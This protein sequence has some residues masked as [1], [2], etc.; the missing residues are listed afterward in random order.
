M[1][2][3]IQ[4]IAQADADFPEAIRRATP[5]PKQ[6]FIRTSHGQEF[7]TILDK[8]RVAIVGSRKVSPYG[9]TATQLLVSEL[10]RAGIVIVSGLAIGVDA[11]AHRTA[12]EVGGQTI[13]ILPGSVEEIYPRSH[14]QLAKQIV[15]Q[16]GALVSEYPPGTVT[17]PANFIA[18][19]RLVAALANV[20]LVIEA[21]QKSGTLHTTRFALEQGID[22]MAVPGNI[23]SPTSQGTNNLLRSGA[24]LATC[25][26]DVLYMLGLEPAQT[27]AAPRSSDP[28]EQSILDLLASGV[29]DGA[30]LLKGSNLEV[31]AYNQALTMLEISGHIRSLGAN[32]W[33][34]A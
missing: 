20:L 22:V 13:A 12:L 11:C 23:T 4:I 9:K 1:N 10:A 25:A 31:S 26:E 15:G 32:K 24:S 30:A 27:K 6:L 8:P 16:G 18:R 34:L 33:S 28:R 3:T 7:S 5:T 17:Y 21:T 29:Q 14:T 2:D 19:N